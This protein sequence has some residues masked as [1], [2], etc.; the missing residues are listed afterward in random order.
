VAARRAL[1]RA[2]QVGLDP[3][4]LVLIDETWATTNLTRL[5]GRAARGQ[6]VVDSVPPGPWKTTTRISALALR[7]IRGS[8]ELDG[9]VH[10]LAFQAFVEPVLT[11][12]LRPAGLVI[13]DHLSSHKGPRV[14]GLVRNAQAAWVYQP[15]SSPAL[16]PLSLALSQ[17]PPAQWISATRTLDALRSGLPSVLSRVTPSVAANFFRP[18]GYTLQIN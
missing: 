11:P 10:G 13:L 18:C 2:R 9:A 15:P 5:R 8:L 14:A 17:I 16:H 12:T 6:R 7:G 3:E 4:R 1:W